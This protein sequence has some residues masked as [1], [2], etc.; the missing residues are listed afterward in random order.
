MVGLDGKRPFNREISKGGIEKEGQ[1]KP[2]TK[3]RRVESLLCWVTCSRD[4]GRC[5]CLD[6]LDF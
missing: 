2:S 5:D 1:T 6:A 3:M 4:R